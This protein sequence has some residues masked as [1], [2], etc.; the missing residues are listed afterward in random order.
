MLTLD[1]A[2]FPE[3]GRWDLV[4]GGTNMT[5]EPRPIFCLACGSEVPPKAKFCP[6]CWEVIDTVGQ[7]GVPKG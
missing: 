4:A 5:D 2:E 3:D 6:N 7:K 1:P